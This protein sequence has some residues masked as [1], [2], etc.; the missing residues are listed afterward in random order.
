MSVCLQKQLIVLYGVSEL[1]F[2][3]RNLH[4][5]TQTDMSTRDPMGPYLSLLFTHCVFFTDVLP[6]N[7]TSPVTN[8]DKMF[9]VIMKR[10]VSSF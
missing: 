3:T 8:R 9:G 4:L 2:H 7:V 5:W 1:L 6:H 10:P